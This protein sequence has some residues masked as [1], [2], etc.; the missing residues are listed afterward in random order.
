MLKLISICKEAKFNQA[1]IATSLQ[2]F[3]RFYLFQSMI[4]L[5]P[6]EVLYSCIFLGIKLEACPYT[7]VY[8]FSDKLSKLA[9]KS[10]ISSITAREV[11]L[12]TA[13]EFCIACHPPYV[14]TRSLL[15]ECISSFFQSLSND[16]LNQEKETLISKWNLIQG[17]CMT[18]IE[19]SLLSDLGF[20]YPPAYISIGILMLL[21]NSPS[22]LFQGLEVIWLDLVTSSLDAKLKTYL[23]EWVTRYIEHHQ[24][25]M[26]HINSIK[27]I[28]THHIQKV[29]TL[30]EKYS[31][32]QGGHLSDKLFTQL[33]QIVQSKWIDANTAVIQA[34]RLEK[35]AYKEE[36]RS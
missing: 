14:S 13:L 26:K 15:K 7:E 21:S 35:K 34:G 30:L 20:L 2:L 27:S 18:L 3:Q 33:E 31:S 8:V 4:L 25:N 9:K 29:S 12:L 22:R 24:L 10:S 36:K 17:V 5:P 16:I 1:I 6:T 23:N 32:P 11:Q 28:L 19:V